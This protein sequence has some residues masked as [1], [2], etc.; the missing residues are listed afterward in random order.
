[1]EERSTLISDLAKVYNLHESKDECRDAVRNNEQFD[2]L[3][4]LV[5]GSADTAMA[6]V[7]KLALSTNDTFWGYVRQLKQY[8]E[9]QGINTVKDR[10]GIEVE[11]LLV[12]SGIKKKG[13]RIYMNLYYWLC[14]QNNYQPSSDQYAVQAWKNKGSLEYLALV[15]L[16]V[17]F[18]DYINEQAYYE[19]Q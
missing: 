10:N 14:E 17:S 2:R 12:N 5:G 18:D 7:E 16:N 19:H 11:V 3:K 9:E 13:Q 6:S 4:E 1:M 8:K 15:E